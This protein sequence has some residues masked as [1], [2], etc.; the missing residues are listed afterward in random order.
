LDNGVSSLIVKRRSYI[1][2]DENNLGTSPYKGPE[3]EGLMHGR[4]RLVRGLIGTPP[5]LR[6]G[7]NK[8]EWTTH[9]NPATPISPAVV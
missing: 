9:H 3:A 7:L 8:Y 5:T 1:G 4:I 2:G 6:F